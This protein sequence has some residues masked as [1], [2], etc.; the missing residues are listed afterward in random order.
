MRI[1]AMRQMILA[2]D[3]KDRKDALHRLLFMQREDITELFQIMDG[4]PVTI[5]LFDPPL[6][7]FLPNTEAE[8][9]YVARAAGV[10]V[11][12][13]RRRATELREFNPM[14]GHRGCRLAITYPEICE[15]QARAI[16]G[17]AAEAGRTSPSKKTPVAEVMVPLVATLEEFKIIK[18]II[19][20]TAA[21]VQ[22]EEPLLNHFF[23]NYLL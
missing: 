7:E 2:S 12:R 15:M 1:T 19:D 5:R 4:Q 9:S 20:K 22:K 16:F 14:L 18:G 3:T 13:V 8:L 6:H 21:A 11:E 23:Q 10:P 17:A